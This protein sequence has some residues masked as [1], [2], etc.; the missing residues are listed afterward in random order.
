MEEPQKETA[1]NSSKKA[2]S[3]SLDDDF[4]KDFLTSWKSTKFGNDAMDFD[5]EKSEGKGKGKKFN[6][7][8]L[9]DFDLDADFDKLPSFNMDMS[10]LDI[11]SPIKM[12]TT[13][14]STEKSLKHFSHGKDKE[15]E[16]FSFSFDFD[17]LGKFDLDLQRTQ[18]TAE[19][20]P[21]K[22]EKGEL[23]AEKMDIP[24]IDSAKASSK[25][26]TS[27]SSSRPPSTEERT[28]KLP[29]CDLS[30]G[31]D[32]LTRRQFSVPSISG[33][34]GNSDNKTDSS[35][36]SMEMRSA[37]PV[38]SSNSRDNVSGACLSDSGLSKNKDST[39][40]S[41]QNE[42]GRNSVGVEKGLYSTATTSA[43]QR[44]LNLSLGARQEKPI[45]SLLYKA[46]PNSALTSEKLSDSNM[47]TELLNSDSEDME[48]QSN[49]ND[50]HAKSSLITETEKDSKIRASVLVSN[51]KPETGN[52]TLSSPKNI[53]GSLPMN[54]ASLKSE[55]QTV[56]S[57][58]STSRRTKMNQISPSAAPESDSKSRE[59]MKTPSQLPTPLLPNSA[60][61]RKHALLSP[62]LKR[63]A[64][65]NSI[66]DPFIPLK[67]ILNS[68]AE[69]RN[70]PLVALKL[71]CN[72]PLESRKSP[73]IALKSGAEMVTGIE[74]V[75]AITENL[76][77]PNCA[78]QTILGT[79][80]F[81]IPVLVLENN[82]NVEK[83]EA[84]SK[85]L[86]DISSMLK[87]KEEEAKEL[88]VR[89][90]VSNNKLLM[91]NHPIYADK[92]SF[93]ILSIMADVS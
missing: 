38:T 12:K 7:A 22:T 17:D 74:S 31:P 89:A 15:T 91:L 42:S 37:R 27:S 39:T 35:A 4:G 30:N 63:K 67:R 48:R 33:S 19:F 2:T 3:T 46:Q 92:I 40:L 25:P 84:I 65:E 49:I 93:F 81:R 60:P 77:S 11:S 80:E 5:V 87:K 26:E 50:T 18:S 52:K 58:P 53:D 82:G 78:N 72:S 20:G 44:N 10:D 75:E 6:F 71:T 83:A 76:K 66:P 32:R 51:D 59:I 43:T 56:I 70:C 73:E 55:K 1:P 8:K 29:S 85:E 24:K 54:N 34:K 86:G 61:K 9:D 62:P 45:S 36:Q 79:A 14:P 13:K 88:L 21:N 41:A 90:I 16:S 57:N 28:S 68:P 23:S 64:V 47:R 69:A